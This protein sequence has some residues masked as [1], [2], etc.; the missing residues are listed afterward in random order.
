MSDEKI[1]QASDIN[2]NESEKLEDLFISEKTLEN[3]TEIIIQYYL[4]KYDNNVMKVSEILD[5]GKST[6]Y[7]MLKKSRTTETG[8]HYDYSEGQSNKM[9]IVA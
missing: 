4:K 7:N 6:I 3:Y 5:I 9:M 1:I 2:F 8:I